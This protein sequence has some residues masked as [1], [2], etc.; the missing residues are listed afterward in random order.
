MTFTR[1]R[2]IQCEVMPLCAPLLK[3]DA[4]LVES[5][6]FGVFLSKELGVIYMS[7]PLILPVF[8]AFKPLYR[9]NV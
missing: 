5:G 1:L 9:G 2:V 4:A 6:I 3:F 8:E 7:R